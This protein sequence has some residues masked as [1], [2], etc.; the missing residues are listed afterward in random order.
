MVKEFGGSG[1]DHGESGD[2]GGVDIA[3][4]QAT[5]ASDHNGVVAGKATTTESVGA[6]RSSSSSSSSASMSMSSSSSSSD[7]PPPR[8]LR[9]LLHQQDN[10]QDPPRGPHRHPPP[11][12]PQA[13]TPGHSQVTKQWVRHPQHLADPQQQSHHQHALGLEHNLVKVVLVLA[14][15]GQ[16]RNL[17]RVGPEERPPCMG[18]LASK[19]A[20]G[21]LRSQAP[22]SVIPNVYKSSNGLKPPVGWLCVVKLTRFIRI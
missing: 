22:S 14:P 2:D 11:G 18:P 3:R 12:P 16:A 21:T 17:E 13:R 5:S 20:Q 10:R 15:Q 4:S 7:D 8:P 19:A 6:R 9:H 1:E